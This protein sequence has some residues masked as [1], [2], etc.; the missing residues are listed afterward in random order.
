M[1]AQYTDY[2]NDGE[3]VSFSVHDPYIHPEATTCSRP[4]RYSDGMCETCP[5]EEYKSDVGKLFRSIPESMMEDAFGDH[6]MVTVHADGTH[7]VSEFTSHD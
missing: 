4:H 7:E 6:V 5:D 2:F 3:A 1:W